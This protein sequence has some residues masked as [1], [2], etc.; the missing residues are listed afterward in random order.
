ML[1]ED[2]LGDPLAALYHYRQTLAAQPSG[3]AAEFARQAVARV[4]RDYVAGVL[5]TAA[6]AAVETPAP[7]PED[8][9]A[10]KEMTRELAEQRQF[11]LAQLQTKTGEASA[12]RGQVQ[13]LQ[14][15]LA[16]LK[17][18]PTPPTPTAATPASGET[19]HTVQK[20]DT[21]IGIA[22]EHYGSEK[23]W[24]QLRDHNQDVLRGGDT[25]R[26]GMKI[27]LP[28]KRELD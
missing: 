10:L 25:L 28:A 14:A 16:T 7:P 9:E 24:R 23:Y 3:E 27:R 5:G 15:E 22:R 21:L 13:A 1:Y 17:A 11:L 6:T 8:I 2:W 20:G 12:W 4:E 26:P 19:L 18:V